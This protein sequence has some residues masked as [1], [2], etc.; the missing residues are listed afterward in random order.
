V[1]NAWDNEILGVATD[2]SG[3]VYRFAH[4]YDT[5]QSSVFSAEDAI[6]DVSADGKYYFWTTDWDGMLGQYGGGANS[7][8]V[9]GQT[10]R[11][12]VFMA[13]LS[14]GSVGP[15]PP[16]PP[17]ALAITTT[18]LPNGQVGVAY[19]MPLVA[20]GGTGP[21]T[22][23]VTGLPA[24]LSQSGATI[25]GA[26]TAAGSPNVTIKV[27]DSE[28]PTVSVSET[29]VL[30]ITAAPSPVFVVTTSLPSGQVGTP[31]TSTTLVASGGT[32]PYKWSATGLA[33]GL[34]TT[35]G[36]VIS[37]TP[38]TAGTFQE[39]IT[40]TDSSSPV[41]TANM[42]FSVLML[43]GI[44]SGFSIGVASGGST[45]ATV[46]AGQ[47]ATYNL[48][49]NPIGGLTGQ[50]TLTCTGAPQ[51]STCMLP[52]AAPVTGSAAVPFTVNIITT[53]RS[54]TPVLHNPIFRLL[55]H[56][57]FAP[58]VTILLM[59]LG[60]TLIRRWKLGFRISIATTTVILLSLLTSCGSVSPG[61]NSSPSTGAGGT[62][63]GNYTLVITGSL[64][65]VSHTLN[66][67]LTVQ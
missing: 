46:A 12:D 47:A 58:F 57:K 37:G 4:T 30:T 20:T 18:S 1:T 36:G 24:G 33:P 48:Q 61:R 45:S 7:C 64:Q 40:V 15:P 21:Y 13:L 14:P 67:T 5:N 55:V 25:S 51:A 59:L 3:T 32:T 60:T 65:N 8:S 66:L 44:S 56:Q 11:T 28:S 6:G 17:P 50:V 62:P 27:T 42:T 63:S 34:T 35:S 49:I 39:V 26:P 10:C 2:G 31:Y 52:A 43:A 53:A 41:Q 16:P 22:W 19:S 9:S 54:R 23:G 38:T 29:V